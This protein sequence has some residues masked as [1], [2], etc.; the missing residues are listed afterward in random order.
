[1]RSRKRRSPGSMRHPSKPLSIRHLAVLLVIGLLAQACTAAVPAAGST[2]GVAAAQETP[3][4]PRGAIRVGEELYQIPIGA[5][6]DGCPR[7][8]LYSPT[9]LVAQAIYYRDAAGG[10]TTNRQEAAC[11]TGLPG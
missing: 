7:F 1:M 10:F 8:R 9:K 4:A 5:D 2:S 6:D 3:H 11:P